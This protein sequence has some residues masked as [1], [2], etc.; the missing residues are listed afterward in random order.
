M[1]TS[2]NSILYSFIIFLVL[3]S[4]INC[5]SYCDNT[6]LLELGEEFCK[7]GKGIDRFQVKSSKKI[8]WKKPLNGKIKFKFTTNSENSDVLKLKKCIKISPSFSQKKRELD[9]LTAYFYEN[10]PQNEATL[11]YTNE[12][13]ILVKLNHEGKVKGNVILSITNSNSTLE[14]K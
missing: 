4:A 5:D 3:V 1:V 13:T 6:P 11:L 12:T 2:K 8:N 7:D 10:V 14:K 9:E